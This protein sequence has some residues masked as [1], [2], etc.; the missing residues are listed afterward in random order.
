MG[1]DGN[2][3][4]STYDPLVTCRRRLDWTGRDRSQAS[5]GAGLTRLVDLDV[6]LWT[7]IL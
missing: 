1:W 4:V 2:T 3:G 5:L 7:G 6:W